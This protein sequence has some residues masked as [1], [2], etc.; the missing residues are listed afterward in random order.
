M[1]LSSQPQRF[2][3]VVPG[4]AN[5]GPVERQDITADRKQREREGQDTVPSD[6][7]P[8]ARPQLLKFPEPSK[9][10][11]PTEDKPFKTINSFWRDW[12]LDCISKSQ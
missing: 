5:S 8:P 1:S 12:G 9:I 6:L 2:L 3:S 4:S 11:P 7:F 10:V